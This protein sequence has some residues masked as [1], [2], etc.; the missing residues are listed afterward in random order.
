MRAA[1][2]TAATG[3]A[4]DDTLGSRACDEVDH[5]FL[6]KQ[7]AWGN[8]HSSITNK[9]PL[10]ASPASLALRRM[11]TEALCSAG[12]QGHKQDVTT[13][14]VVWQGTAET[15]GSKRESAR[16]GQ[17][18]KGL[19]EVRHKGIVLQLLRRPGLQDGAAG[20]AG[21]AVLRTEAF[22]WTDAGLGL[23]TAAELHMP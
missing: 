21:A 8:R 16:A 12:L 1:T 11:Q 15:E 7:H 19:R 14:R 18:Y 3:G 2:A 5:G 22:K 10:Q 17:K 4:A 9:C 13:P 20:A 6:G 23:G